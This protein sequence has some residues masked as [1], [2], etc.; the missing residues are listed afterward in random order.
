MTQSIFFWHFCDLNLILIDAEH[1]L[2]NGK[3]IPY[4]TLREPAS[5]WTRADAI[6]ITKANISSANT[7]YEIEHDRAIAIAKAIK[8]AKDLAT[9]KL[10]AV[11]GGLFSG[12]AGPA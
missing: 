8:Q 10:Q 5:Q 7:V 12:G 2:G 3:L 1:G 9:N 6:I 4:G 11:T